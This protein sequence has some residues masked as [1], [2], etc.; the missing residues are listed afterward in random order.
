MFKQSYNIEELTYNNWM[1]LELPFP[2]SSAVKLDNVY[3]TYDKSGE[4]S[5]KQ[6]SKVP[7]ECKKL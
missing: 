1:W 7:V 4:K 6:M 2:K 5:W 3:W